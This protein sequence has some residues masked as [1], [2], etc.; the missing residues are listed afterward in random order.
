ML[1]LLIRCDSPGDFFKAIRSGKASVVTAA[2]DE[3]TPHGIRLQET[4]TI[5]EA[6][7]VVTATGLRLPEA[8][9]DTGFAAALRCLIAVLLHCL[10]CTCLIECSFPPITDPKYSVD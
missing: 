5:L 10:L 6:D 7:L 9:G 3:F 1:C 8:N 4:A 2:I